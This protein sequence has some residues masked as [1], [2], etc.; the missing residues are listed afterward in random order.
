MP[1]GIINSALQLEEIATP[2]ATANNGKIYTKTDN[3]LYFQDGAGTE[4]RVVPSD[5]AGIFV[6]GNAVAT[7]ILLVDAW[8]PITIFDTDMPEIVSNGAHGTDNITIGATE[9]YHVSFHLFGSSAANNKVFAFRVFEI[10]ASG[11]TITAATQANPCVVTAV[12]HSL[13][14]GDNVKID[15]VV[16]MVE[17]NGQMYTVA[18]KAADTFELNDD[19]SANIDST[20]YTAYG[21]AGVA[22]LASEVPESHASRKFAV[23]SDIGSISAGGFVS[24]IT[25]D[26][27]ELHVKGTT[28]A[29]NFTVEGA[30]FWMKR[31]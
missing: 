29:T 9:V 22:Y 16:G 19:N 20:G 6:D 31:V 24:L 14:N 12:G 28:D 8:E 25:G 18:N 5:Y 17:L 27:L 13:N 30:Q 26:S 1:D 7:T 23:A 11:D 15:S 21:S 10:A 3:D 2:T 4:H